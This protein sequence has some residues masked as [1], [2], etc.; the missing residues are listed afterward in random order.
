MMSDDE[1]LRMYRLVMM[2]ECKV[3]MWD[4]AD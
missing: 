4:D 3:M 2:I 1:G